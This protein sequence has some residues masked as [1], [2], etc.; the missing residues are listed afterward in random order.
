NSVAFVAVKGDACGNGL[1]GSAQRRAII[2]KMIRAGMTR[3]DV[4]S[5]LGGPESTT[6]TNG[7]DRLRFRDGKGQVRTVSFDEHGC[8]LGKR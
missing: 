1:S 8:V 5:A 3:S 6:S 4:E 2:S 7:R